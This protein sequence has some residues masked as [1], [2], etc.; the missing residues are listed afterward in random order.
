MVADQKSVWDCGK[1]K[2]LKDEATELMI[3]RARE[4]KNKIS[5]C[6]YLSLIYFWSILDA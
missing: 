2:Q 3:E 6:D 5:C 1:S 4:T